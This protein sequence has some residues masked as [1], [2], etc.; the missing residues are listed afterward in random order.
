VCI[1]FLFSGNG[2]GAPEVCD[3]V[4]YLIHALLNS[5]SPIYSHFAEGYYAQ[6]FRLGLFFGILL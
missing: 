2:N 3:F 1:G 5:T 4:F 6:N